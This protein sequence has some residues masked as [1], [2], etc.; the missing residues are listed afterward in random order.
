MNLKELDETL[1]SPETVVN[2]VDHLV[3]VGQLQDEE[4]KTW[5]PEQKLTWASKGN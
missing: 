2:L 4:W 5:T 3:S 1:R